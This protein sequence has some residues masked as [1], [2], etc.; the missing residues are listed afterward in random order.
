[1]SQLRVDVK[2]FS[3]LSDKVRAVL[4][5]GSAPMSATPM[6]KCAIL[7]HKKGNLHGK[8]GPVFEAAQVNLS[9]AVGFGKKVNSEFSR[10]TA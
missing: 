4:D 8:S 2:N 7:P 6:Y 5:V 1:M 10:L 9:L 3:N